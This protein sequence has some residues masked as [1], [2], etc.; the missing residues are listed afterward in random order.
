MKRLRE[1][2]NELVCVGIWYNTFAVQ[3]TKWLCLVNYIGLA[4]NSDKV[5]YGVVGYVFRLCNWCHQ[6]GGGN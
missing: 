5:L 2:L 1:Y 4:V 3:N 6:L